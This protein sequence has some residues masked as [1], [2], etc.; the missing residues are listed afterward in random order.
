[1]RRRRREA[2]RE[3]KKRGR[4]GGREGRRDEYDFRVLE[5]RFKS[6]F[7]YFVAA[8]FGASLFSPHQSLSF[9]ICKLGTIEPI[10][11]ATMK[12]K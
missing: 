6:W 3:G 12:S 4:E 10:F 1:M 11:L 2:G 7:R 8:S 5:A 9:L